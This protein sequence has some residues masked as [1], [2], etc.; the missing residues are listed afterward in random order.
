MLQ[1]RF[2]LSLTRELFMTAFLQYNTQIQNV[3]LNAR[4][5]WRFAPMSDVF[6]VYTDNYGT[7]TFAVRNRG[8]VLKIIYWFN[9]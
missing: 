2:D 6:L 5:Q 9:A 4:L 8:V 3:N 1:A 7:D